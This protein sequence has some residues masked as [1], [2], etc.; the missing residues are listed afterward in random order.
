MK[1]LQRCDGG[2]E[3][4]IRF[5]S[6]ARHVYSMSADMIFSFVVSRNVCLVCE[7]FL[8]FPSSSEQYS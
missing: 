5:K 8:C 7:Q 1:R 3:G 6:E 2:N 4:K